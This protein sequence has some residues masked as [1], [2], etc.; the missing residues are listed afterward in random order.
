ME[1]D[2]RRRGGCGV[3]GR[4]RGEVGNGGG[5]RY[6]EGEVGRGGVG[7]GGEG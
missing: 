3:S 7:E 2:G 4:W 1:E 6:D 5:R